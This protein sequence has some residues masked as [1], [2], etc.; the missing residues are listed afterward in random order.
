MKSY[1]KYT[2]AVKKYVRLGCVITTY[3]VYMTIE[4]QIDYVHERIGAKL[5]N[6]WKVAVR[7]FMVA[8]NSQGRQ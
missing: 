6:G 5:K 2:V 3:P 7:S 1:Q 4:Y 8:K